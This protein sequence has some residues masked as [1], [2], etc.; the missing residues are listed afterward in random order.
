[1]KLTPK[2]IERFWRKVHVGVPEICWVW[3]AYR[4]RQGYGMV[5]FDGKLYLAHR[6]AWALC[7]G[8]IPAEIMVCHTCDNP[9]CC[10]PKHL[11]LG[12]HTDNMRDMQ[13]KDRANHPK[14]D[15]TG[16]R[17]ASNLKM[18]SVSGTTIYRIVHNQMWRRN[19]AQ[20]TP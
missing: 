19:A 5:G 9:P 12:T 20:E 17:I 13:Q 3:H 2:Q 10:N 7:N 6:V 1:M 15:S 16:G 18:F 4:H 8:S 14:G 11:F